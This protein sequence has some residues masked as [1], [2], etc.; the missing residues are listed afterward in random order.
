MRKLIY[1]V[2][3]SADGFIA[4]TDHGM[5]G[6]LSEGDHVS[7]YLA[8]LQNDYDTVL[9]GRKTYDFGLQFGVT[10]PYPWLKQYVISSHNEGVDKDIEVISSDPAALASRMKSEPGKNIYLCGGATL[11]TSL[12]EHGWIDEVLL[13]QNPV[14]FGAGIP[15]FHAVK[16]FVPLELQ[17]TNV[18]ANGVLLLRYAIAN[19]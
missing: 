14:V 18:Y 2:A 12:L 9:M 5:A 8:S 16:S 10:N 11:A 19:D 4:Q 13:K 15:L 7:D 3:T 1:H 17:D 6:F